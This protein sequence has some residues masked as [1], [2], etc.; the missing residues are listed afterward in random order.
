MYIWNY[1]LQ[2][3]THLQALP[4]DGAHAAEFFIANQELFLAI[5][6][7][8]DRHNRRYD[9]KSAVYGYL[10]GSGARS[11]ELKECSS[12]ETPESN[13]SSSISYGNFK[14]LESVNTFGATDWEYFEIN[15][16]EVEGG[17][18]KVALGSKAHFLVVSEEGDM[19][20]GAQSGYL[21]QVFKIEF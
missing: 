1:D 12:N 2:R 20:K 15:L 18:D 5:A 9:S 3:Y 11:D 14:L 13:N 6:N 10:R 8:G 16:T 19:Q 4:T 7:F 21:S 17:D